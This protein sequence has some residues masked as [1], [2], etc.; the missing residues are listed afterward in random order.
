[1]L[2]A[3]HSA[4]VVQPKMV[5]ATRGVISGSSDKVIAFSSSA[6]NAAI[7]S[8]RERCEGYRRALREAGIPEADELY[9]QLSPRGRENDR[10]IEAFL[11]AHPDCHAIF[12]FSD[13]LATEILAVALG[14]KEEL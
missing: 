1:M 5:I 3:R 4:A 10:A 8:G 12:A 6:S 13:L 9:L 7:S 11:T 2:P 14:V